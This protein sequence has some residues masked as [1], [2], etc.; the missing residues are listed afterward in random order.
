MDTTELREMPMKIS[1][2][3]ARCDAEIGR[4]GNVHGC[5]RPAKYRV[6]AESGMYL[7]Y[8]EG[9]KSRTVGGN[10]HNSVK[11]GAEVHTL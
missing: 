4:P 6:W 3:K 5:K 2:T 8:C 1:E 7:E 10:G 9:H 11:F